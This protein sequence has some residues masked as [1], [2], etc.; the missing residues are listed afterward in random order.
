MTTI[1]PYHIKSVL[2]A[3]RLLSGHFK[4][5]HGRPVIDLDYAR[6][7]LIDVLKSHGMSTTDI[8]RSDDECDC[9]D[10]SA[11]REPDSDSECN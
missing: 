6:D 5:E 2:K 9:P 4:D 8:D 11:L 10:C 3:Y 7:L 1:A